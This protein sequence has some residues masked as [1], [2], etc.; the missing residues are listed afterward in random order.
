[1]IFGLLHFLT[2]TYALLAGLMGVYF[3]VL[4]DST[5]SA[6]PGGPNGRARTVRL[7]RVSAPPP[8]RAEGSD[9]RPNV[10]LTGRRNRAER[11]TS[12][13]LPDSAG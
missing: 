3:G 4:L 8:G 2:P 12:T 9:S 5:Q 7:P 10:T 6:Q 11:A 1:M 13:S